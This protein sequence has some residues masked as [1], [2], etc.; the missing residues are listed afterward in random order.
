MAMNVERKAKLEAAG[1]TVT[2]VDEFLGLTP[3]E[4]EKVDRLAMAA[5][6]VKREDTGTKRTARI[7][8]KISAAV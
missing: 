6:Q 1:F 7:S 3:E 8:R 4:S 5:I 2:T